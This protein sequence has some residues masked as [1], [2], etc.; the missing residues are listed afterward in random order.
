[1]TSAIDPD[2]LT[3]KQIDT[4]LLDSGLAEHEI[5]PSV[6]AAAHERDAKKYWKRRAFDR[7]LPQLKND[8]R[9]Q[10]FLKVNNED[11]CREIIRDR[12]REILDGY[13]NRY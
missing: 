8:Q 6:D 9:Y 13:T 12:Y 7:L 3:D 10:L 4:F 1:M 11:G 2:R 5:M